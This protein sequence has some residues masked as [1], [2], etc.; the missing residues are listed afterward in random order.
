MI[1]SNSVTVIHGS[2]GSGKTTQVPQYILDDCASRNEYCN[3]IVTQPR[4]IAAM[5]V[6]QRVCAERGCQLGS[7]CGYQVSVRGGCDLGNICNTYTNQ[8]CMCAYA[9]T[10]CG[11]RLRYMYMT[12]LS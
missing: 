8:L 1:N 7:I 10:Q 3:I 11:M 9:S 2:T 5:S 12:S 6:A 4:R